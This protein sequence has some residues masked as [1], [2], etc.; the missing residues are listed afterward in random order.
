[1]A[2]CVSIVVVGFFFFSVQVAFEDRVVHVRLIQLTRRCSIYIDPQ[3]TPL[4][5][6]VFVFYNDLDMGRW[7]ATSTPPLLPSLL[8]LCICCCL[9]FYFC[10]GFHSWGEWGRAGN[11]LYFDLGMVGGGDWVVGGF[12]LCLSFFLSVSLCGHFGVSTSLVRK[13]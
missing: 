4:F 13:R 8:R 11:L 2:R 1:M 9:V 6:K 5:F 12:A 7:G 3:E 10:L